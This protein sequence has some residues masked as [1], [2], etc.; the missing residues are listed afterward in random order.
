MLSRRALMAGTAALAAGCSSIESAFDVPSQPQVV[1]LIWASEAFSG[2]TER[3]FGSRGLRPTLQ[4]I[5]EALA[6]DSENPYG[7]IQ[8]R[9]TLTP[10]FIRSEQA[11]PPPRTVDDLL[12]W[13]GSLE[14]DLLS[15]H[16][17]IAQ[18]LAERGVIL[19][20]D[21]F[22]AAEGPD[23]AGA[24][25][26]YLLDYFRSDAG[27]FAL[28]V[29]ADPTMVQYDPKYFGEQGVPPVDSSWDWDDLVENAV[30]LT[31]R[32]D[33]G[34]VRR[35]GLVTQHLGYWWALWQNNADVAEPTTKQCR[36][37]ES[38]AIAALQFCYD[39]LH[40]RQVSPPLTSRDGWQVFRSRSGAWPAMYYTSNQGSWSSE[41][42]W[43]ALPQGKV[44]SV[45][46]IADMGIA[47]AAHAKNPEVAYAALKGLLGVMQRF[48]N[49]PAQKEAVARMSDFRKTLLPEEVTAFQQS[50]E[51]GRGIPLNPAMWR[52]MRAIEEGLV[53]GDDVITVVNEACSLVE[54]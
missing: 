15:V 22:I 51:Y 25:Y 14:T 11:N 30:K 39:L 6:E 29:D 53:R 2:L 27:L 49:V 13:Y 19:P 5:V 9:Y 28:P 21:Q 34:E 48:V 20:L 35:W 36:L 23:F 4:Q 38:A 26:P 41:Y 45:P 52:A 31:Q 37:Q 1:D 47:I 24:F 46:V 12:A 44:R 18:M 16:P 8:G 50:M 17:L 3:G 10:R 32:H 40:V 54:A 42:R 7:P 33:D 43:A